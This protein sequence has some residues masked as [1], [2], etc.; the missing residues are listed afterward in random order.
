MQTQGLL[1]SEVNKPTIN[2]RDG[3][4]IT[5]LSSPC[6]PSINFSIANSPVSENNK[7]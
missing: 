4:K 6:I 2:T 1:K 7:T 3:E 5:A